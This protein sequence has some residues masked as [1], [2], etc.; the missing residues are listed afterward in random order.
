MAFGR[1]APAVV[2]FLGFCEIMITELGGQV[3][4]L[5][6]WGWLPAVLL[7]APGLVTWVSVR[8]LQWCR[9]EFLPY[10]APN[11]ATLELAEYV[12]GWWWLVCGIALWLMAADNRPRTPD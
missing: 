8:V 2:M 3:R 10:I 1:T 4:G 9:F 7:V 12:T 5:I 6:A 11:V